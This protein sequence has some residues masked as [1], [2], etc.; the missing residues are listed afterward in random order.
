MGGINNGCSGPVDLDGTVTNNQVLNNPA[1]SGGTISGT[2]VNNSTVNNSTLNNPTIHGT[3]GLDATATDSLCAALTPCV[4]AQIPD[5]LPPSGPAGGDLAGTY[6]NPTLSPNATAKPS[7]PAGGD[8]QGT[9]PNPTVKPTVIAGTFKDCTGADQL[10]GARIPTCDQMSTAI[11]NAISSFNPDIDA[12]V[13]AGIIASSVPV[14]TAIAGLFPTCDGTPRT[15]RVPMPSCDEMFAA[16]EDAINNGAP[17]AG[18]AGGDLSGTY[19]NPTVR[20]ATQTELGI[21]ELATTAEAIAGTSNTV[22][23]TPA[24]TTAQVKDL[25][26]GN[27]CRL[28]HNAGV[29][30]IPKPVDVVTA[31]VGSGAKVL[32]IA[33]VT[34]R[35]SV[36]DA[37]I[38]FNGSNGLVI[39]KTGLYMIDFDLQFQFA[40]SAAARINIQAN[41]L[42]N[43]IHTADYGRGVF[44]LFV[45][46]NPFVSDTHFH[47]AVSLSKGDVLQFTGNYLEGSDASIE[48]QM[49]DGFV[50]YMAQV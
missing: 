22:A 38:T 34:I 20:H 19:P 39:N 18:V 1:I 33:N 12:S 40:G 47:G 8:L 17:P 36:G 16:I 4:Q 29:N 48:M 50:S 6:P 24:S 44:S 9:Y 14:Q 31:A 32:P 35:N 30:A 5:S 23:M 7:G 27:A 46:A 37:P 11:A 26:Q 45:P 43:N 28:I 41:I 10:A 49:L 25:T 2:T 21:V 3:I 13:I 42:V 15:V